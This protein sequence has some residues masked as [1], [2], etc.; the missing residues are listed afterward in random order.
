MS[1]A[2]FI[3][4]PSTKVKSSKVLLASGLLPASFVQRKLY[5]TFSGNLSFQMHADIFTFI[6]VTS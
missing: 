5:V 1:V 2:L 6:Y 3:F 4:F